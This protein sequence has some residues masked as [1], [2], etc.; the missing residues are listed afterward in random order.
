M[1][2]NSLN[3][4]KLNFY[5]ILWIIIWLS[6]GVNPQQVELF[7]IELNENNITINNLIKFLRIII[8]II[9]S[10]FLLFI[11]IKK[12]NNNKNFFYSN[13]SILLIN[14]FIFNQ[15]ISL[16][17]SDNSI[18]NIYWIYQSF[19]SL[20]LI[21][22]IIRENFL[23]SKIVVNLSV[24][25]LLI[26]LIIYTI[27]FF[28]KFFSSHLS[29]Y[30]MWPG[31]YS[32][33]FSAPRPTGLSRTSLIV[34]IFFLIYKFENKKLSIIKNTIIVFCSLVI[35][36]FQSRTILFL[37]PVL[38][39]LYLFLSKINFKQKFKKII[40][41]IIL[42]ILL[43]L[44]LNSL[45]YLITY[46]NLFELNITQKI[47]DESF[48]FKKRNIENKKPTQVFRDT[49]PKSFSSYRTLHWRNIFNDTKKNFMG[50]GPMGDRYII[51]M[52]ASSLFFYA[53]ASSGFVGL[54]FIILLSLR[55]AYLVVYFIFYKKIIYH[56]QNIYL[57]YSCFVLI[58]LFLR[59]ILETSLGIFSIDYLLFIIASLICEINYSKKKELVK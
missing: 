49:D 48:E 45:R 35:L 58:I 53:L 52:S 23:Y 37:W 9:L 55:S 54:I 11:F 56:N 41:Y 38:I 31:V 34:M 44:S 5:F 40:I 22:L 15:L 33:D 39:I 57:I 25:I 30:N 27:P 43:F 20:I 16:I 50:H 1:K 19:I 32:H 26:V 59:G 21:Y 51:D 14:L 12:I 17:I 10:I 8:P 3:N 2:F 7:F 28:L 6:I 47:F 29:F 46:T 13:Y 18:V 42:P 36:L 4:L 24:L